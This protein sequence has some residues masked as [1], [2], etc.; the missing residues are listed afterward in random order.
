[1]TYL[2][3]AQQTRREQTRGPLYDTYASVG[4]RESTFRA[5]YELGSAHRC[6]TLPPRVLHTWIVVHV[7]SRTICC[8]SNIQLSSSKIQYWLGF[9]DS[10]G[11][12]Y[13]IFIQGYF[14]TGFLTQR[15]IQKRKAKILNACYSGS[16]F[17]KRFLTTKQSC[18]IYFVIAKKQIIAVNILSEGY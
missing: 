1:M 11:N 8:R 4:G 13:G 14:Y 6:R 18:K 3:K 15:L 5:G 16:V 2:T 9:G 7:E 10:H 17:G 12:M